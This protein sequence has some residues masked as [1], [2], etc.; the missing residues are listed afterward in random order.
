MNYDAQLTRAGEGRCPGKLSWGV[1]SE[2]RLRE[3][4]DRIFQEVLF[5]AVERV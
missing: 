3:M 4:L 5:R 2:E 1:V